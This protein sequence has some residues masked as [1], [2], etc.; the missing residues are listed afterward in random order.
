MDRQMQ[1]LENSLRVKFKQQA[2]FNGIYSSL[3]RC[4]TFSKN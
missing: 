3:P 1:I 2:N 4:L